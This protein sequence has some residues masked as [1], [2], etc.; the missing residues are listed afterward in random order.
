[1]ANSRRRVEAKGELGS[2]LAVASFE[3]LRVL[4]WQLCFFGAVPGSLLERELRRAAAD[5]SPVARDML[6][7]MA[8]IA[9]TGTRDW[10]EIPK[11]EQ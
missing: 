6:E 3:A 1:M 9:H 7:I 2:P 11:P 8:A 10:D 4:I 5:V